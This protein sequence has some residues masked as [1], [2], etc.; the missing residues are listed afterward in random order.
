MQVLDCISLHVIRFFFPVV[1]VQVNSCRPQLEG[2]QLD[3]KGIKILSNRYGFLGLAI[4]KIIEVA[5]RID[6]RV[7]E[8]LIQTLLVPRLNVFCRGSQSTSEK[9]LDRCPRIWIIWIC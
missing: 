9:S 3:H 8:P 7:F 5:V 2:E 4:H 1:T 6:F